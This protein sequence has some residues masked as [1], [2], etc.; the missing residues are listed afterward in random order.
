MIYGLEIT[1]AHYR[2][3]QVLS[4][5]FFFLK[6]CSSA[7]IKRNKYISNALEHCPSSCTCSLWQWQEKILIQEITG[8][9]TIWSWTC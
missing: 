9:W 7:V 6:I 3:K 5:F 4:S 2:A 8:A 1:E